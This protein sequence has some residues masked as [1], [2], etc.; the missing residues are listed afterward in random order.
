MSYIGLP[1][2]VS[3]VFYCRPEWDSLI[4]R[5]DK[6]KRQQRRDGAMIMLATFANTDIHHSSLMLERDDKSVMI[7]TGEHHRAKMIDTCWYHENILAPKYI[8]E[9]GTFDVSLK[10]LKNYLRTPYRLKRWDVWVYIL[11]TRFFFP[12]LLPKTCTLLNCQLLRMIGYK[13]EDIVIPML[14]WKELKKNY[15]P[16][17]W[18]EYNSRS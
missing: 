4:P 8:I 5:N 6:L 15:K 12:T 16:I 11:I 9:L 7:I 17:T 13:I 14:L 1:T 10:Q 2:K 3:V 18:D